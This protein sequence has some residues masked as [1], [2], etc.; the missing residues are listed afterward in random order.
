MADGSTGGAYQQMPRKLR[1]EGIGLALWVILGTAMS[2]TPRWCFGIIAISMLPS[3]YLGW[4]FIRHYPKWR[5]YVRLKSE[6]ERDHT[7]A[8]A[9]PTNPFTDATE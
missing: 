3:A 8:Q 4:C 2:V 6:Y 9:P 1:V 5:R 7:P